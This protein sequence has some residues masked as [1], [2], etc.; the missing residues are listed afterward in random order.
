MYVQ[1]ATDA[2]DTWRDWS[3]NLTNRCPTNTACTPP[4]GYKGTVTANNVPAGANVWVT[5]HLDY[6]L[7][8]TTQASTWLKTPKTYG[9]FQSD[10]KIKVGNAVVGTST[11]QAWLLG[12]G[13]KVTG[14]LRVHDQR[15][16]EH[17]APGDV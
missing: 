8:G 14:H 11:S 9:P 2:P 1:Y 17:R 15:D 3:A 13:K 10:I 6:A 7:K 4:A 5:V 12:R 16:R